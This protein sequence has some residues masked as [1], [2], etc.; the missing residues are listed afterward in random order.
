[1]AAAASLFDAYV[2]AALQAVPTTVAVDGKAAVVAEQLV[3]LVA[4]ERH[5]LRLAAIGVADRKEGGRGAFPA[6]VATARRALVDGL[7]A[8]SVDLVQ[9]ELVAW[10]WSLELA[11]GLTKALA[12]TGTTGD[13]AEEVATAFRELLFDALLAT[14]LTADD[15]KG[16]GGH[17]DISLFSTLL[18]QHFPAKSFALEVDPATGLPE[19]PAPV[20]VEGLPKSLVTLCGLYEYAGIHR[21]KPYFSCKANDY[22]C[23]F[24]A[25]NRWF[26]SPILGDQNILCFKEAESADELLPSPHSPLKFWD[27]TTWGTSA[28]ATLLQLADRVWTAPAQR[29]AKR[30]RVD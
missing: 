22:F 23:Y 11:A 20:V 12:A 3:R 21:G 1:M 13:R 7:F 17:D 16:A 2:A 4:T 5:S 8:G 15:N 10:G 27:G 30:R 29:P 25:D 24:T 19:H 28:E 14:G 9:A 18:R 26:V 6:D